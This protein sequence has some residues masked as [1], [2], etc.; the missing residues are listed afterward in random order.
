MTYKKLKKYISEN[1]STDEDRF[2]DFIPQ[3]IRSKIILTVGDE[4]SNASAFFSSIMKAYSIPHSRYSM[5]ENIELK[6]RFLR[7]LSPINIDELSTVA[8]RIVRRSQKMILSENLLFLLALNLLSNNEYLLIDVSL[9]L[10]Q[11]L[12]G[13]IN[14]YAI[15]FALNDDDKAE[16][17]IASASAGTKYIISLAQRNDYSYRPTVTAPCGATVSYASKNKITV[18]SADI[19]GTDFFHYDYLYH[20]PTIDQNNVP[21]AHL[22]IESA[23]LIFA[24]IRPKIHDGLSDARDL[25]DLE[26]YSLSPAVYLRNGDNNFVL[27]HRMKFNIVTNET[28]F[29]PPTQNTVFCGNIEY[30]DKIK[31]CLKSR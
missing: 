15:I 31:K 14:P 8:D 29:V 12:I 19:M 21:L 24:A 7:S 22:A 28:D 9:S 18:K 17:L 10:Y 2:F 13:R 23:S 16:E 6:N 1:K 30:I 25:Y 4:T 26:L 27:H 11:H 3:N 20:I 5:A